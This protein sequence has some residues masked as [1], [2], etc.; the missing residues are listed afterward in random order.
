MK[1]PW[2]QD[3]VTIVTGGASGIGRAIASEAA[4]AGAITVISDIN[5]KEGIDLEKQLIEKG[6]HSKFVRCDVTKAEE[7]ESM[8]AQAATS[9]LSDF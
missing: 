8:V 4:S 9:A 3:Q 6:F 1:Q 5:E 2:I 7:V